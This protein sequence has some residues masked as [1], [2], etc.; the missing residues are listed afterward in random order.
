MSDLEIIEPREVPLG[1]LR[2]MTVRRTLPSR[3]RSLIGAWCFLDHYGPDDLAISEPMVVP[4]HPHTGLATV[5]WLFTGEVDHRDSG[6]NAAR[7]RPGELNLMTAG[8]GISHSEYSTAETQMLHGCQLWLALPRTARDTAPRF[9]AY[10]P[11]VVS[12]EGWEARVFLGTLAGSRSPVETHTPL[13]GAE[14]LLEEGSSVTFDV[15]PDFEHGVLI[16]SGEVVVDGDP[17]GSHQLGYVAPG[18]TTMT[19]TATADSRLML[20][21]GVPF[22]EEIVMWWNFIGRSHE[23]IVEY[24]TEWESLL[25]TGTSDR[26]SLP[27]ADPMAALHAPPMPAVRLRSRR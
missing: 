26:F 11:P 12:G 22:G 27:D 23:D 21:G 4:P 20:L 5:S 10:V 18:A 24:R 1:G 14:V 16:D 19:L 8:R 9:E 15:Y 17:L 7:V 25:E 6:G 13:L 3:E 2:A